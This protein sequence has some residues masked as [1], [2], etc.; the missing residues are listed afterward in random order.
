MRRGAGLLIAAAGL[1][2]GLAAAAAAPITGQQPAPVTE[3]VLRETAERVLARQEELSRIWP[4][5]WPAQQPFILHEPSVGAVFAGSAAPD[6]PEYRPGALPG[7]L[8]TFELD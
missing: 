1:W 2:V 7:A 5:F 6:G 4:G 8:S 3:A